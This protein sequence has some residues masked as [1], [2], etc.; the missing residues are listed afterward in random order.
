[1]LY[2]LIESLEIFIEFYYFAHCCLTCFISIE[3]KKIFKCCVLGF[4]NENSSHYKLFFLVL[5][6]LFQMEVPMHAQVAR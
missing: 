2:Q 6:Q 4:L 5:D 3:K 1:M